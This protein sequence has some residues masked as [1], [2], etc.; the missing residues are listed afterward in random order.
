MNVPDWEGSDQEFQ[1]PPAGW[2]DCAKHNWF[3]QFK[4][5]AKCT[6]EDE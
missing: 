2:F 3:G 4:P 6:Q 5:C 1:D